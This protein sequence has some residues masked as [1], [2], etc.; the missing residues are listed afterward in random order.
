MA[1]V[2]DVTEQNWDA[3]VL[4]SETPVLVDFWAPWCG[5]CRALAPTVDAVAQELSGRVKV[6][7]LNVDDAGAV[8]GRYGVQGIPVLMLFKGGKVVDQIVG[9]NQQKARLIE[10]LETFL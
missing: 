5:P 2:L 7:K 6:V 3:E 1:A 9:G 4:N 10:R 8:A